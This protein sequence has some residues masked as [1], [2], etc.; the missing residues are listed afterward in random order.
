M[1]SPSSSS[2]ALQRPMVQLPVDDVAVLLGLLDLLCPP[3]PGDQDD[4]VQALAH[5][6][7]GRL[8]VAIA[9]AVESP[10]DVHSS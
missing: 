6:F 8:A 10:Q 4:P 9:A 3:A 2:G 5:R 1:T 7:R